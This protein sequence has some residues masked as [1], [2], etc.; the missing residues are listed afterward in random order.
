[1]TDSADRKRSG[2]IA[3]GQFKEIAPPDD[4]KDKIVKGRG[5]DLS[6]I[7]LRAHAAIERLRDD[8]VACARKELAQVDA[9][10]A[11]ARSSPKSARDEKLRIVRRIAT[12]NGRHC[13]QCSGAIP[14]FSGDSLFV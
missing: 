8:F 6:S 13:Q 2:A 7:E 14:C 1:M 10:I 4:W 12:R 5:L 9:A 11:G 3:R